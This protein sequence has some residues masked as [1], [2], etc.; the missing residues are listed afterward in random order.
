[1]DG[2]LQCDDSTPGCG[3]NFFFQAE[4]G[5][6]DDLVTGVQTCALPILFEE[7]VVTINLPLHFLISFSKFK[8]SANSDGVLPFLSAPKLSDKRHNTPLLDNSSIR[9]K[10]VVFLSYG[11]GSSLKSLP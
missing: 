8:V 1:M 11:V 6:R 5:I 3:Y 4:D 9:A 10:S 2:P 7:Y